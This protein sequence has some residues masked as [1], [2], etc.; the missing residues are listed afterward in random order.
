MAG[1]SGIKGEKGD[2]G[3]VGPPG[4]SNTVYCKE[5]RNVS[6]SLARVA[7]SRVLNS[8][9][10]L[11]SV[12]THRQGRHLLRAPAFEGPKTSFCVFKLYFKQLFQGPK[13]YSFN[14][15]NLMID[16]KLIHFPRE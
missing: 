4:K 10:E 2:V 3:P 6:M 11:R 5:N 15:L 13:R 7:G 16:Y 12:L 8:L 9:C 14:L 1:G